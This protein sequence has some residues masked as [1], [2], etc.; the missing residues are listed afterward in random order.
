MRTNPIIEG[1]KEV[2]KKAYPQL[3]EMAK[4]MGEEILE[5]IRNGEIT[6]RDILVNCPDLENADV[7]PYEQDYLTKDEFVQIL[8]QEKVQGSTE[9]A[10]LLKKG[11]EKVYLYTAYVSNGELMPVEANKY[12]IFISDAIAR[13]LESLFDNNELIVL[14]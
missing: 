3:L 12:L 6:P 2:A 7:L 1:L 11:S 5:K 14:H 9:V 4:Q 8:K 13:D 10:A